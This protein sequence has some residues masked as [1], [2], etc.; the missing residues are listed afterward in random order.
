MEFLKKN[1]IGTRVMYPPISSQKA[2]NMRQ[3]L[4]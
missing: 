2:Y 4:P 1:N 3:I